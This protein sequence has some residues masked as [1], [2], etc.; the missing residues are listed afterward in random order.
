MGFF[1]SIRYL[2]IIHGCSSVN[3]QQVSRNCAVLIR[4]LLQYNVEQRLGCGVR[5]AL[6]IIEHSWFDQMNFWSLYQ[7]RYLAPF[8]P[9]RQSFFLPDEEHLNETILKFTANNQYEKEYH[10]F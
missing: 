7:Q 4:D 2:R 10:A 3:L 6:D 9:I 5:G 1:S 8:L